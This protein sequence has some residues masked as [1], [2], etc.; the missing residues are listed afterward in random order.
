MLTPQPAPGPWEQVTTLQPGDVL[1]NPHRW[2]HEV[3]TAGQAVAFSVWTATAEGCRQCNSTTIFRFIAKSFHPFIRQPL[4]AAARLQ[5]KFCLLD[6]SDSTGRHTFCFC[7]SLLL[8]SITKYFMEDILILHMN[9]KT[10][11]SCR[12]CSMQRKVDD[13]L[14]FSSVIRLK[15]RNAAHPAL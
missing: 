1:Y 9:E 2:W 12:R 7:S 6:R 10:V 15:C 4:L 5:K 13:S 8:P 11:G 3:Y 14:P